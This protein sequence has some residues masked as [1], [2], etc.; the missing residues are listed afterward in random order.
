MCHSGRFGEKMPTRSPAL[1]PS[2]S[3]ALETPAIR[4]K[5]SRDDIGSQTPLT[6]SISA[7]SLGTRSI[8]LSNF[9]VSVAKAMV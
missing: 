2:C 9:S 8:A 3:S 6:R 7:R 5:N 1:T 4:R